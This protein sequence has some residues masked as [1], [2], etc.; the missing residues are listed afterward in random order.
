M[1]DRAVPVYNFPIYVGDTLLKPIQLTA[2]AAGTADSLVDYTGF[3]CEVRSAFGG[4]LLG[5]ATVILDDL[6]TG[7]FSIKFPAAVTAAAAP[8]TSVVY[9]VFA[10][11]PTGGPRVLVRGTA[12]PVLGRSTETVPPS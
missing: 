12:C 9:D 1:T 7:Q 6:P 11:D 2:D 4:T 5:S 3:A 8:Y 10:V